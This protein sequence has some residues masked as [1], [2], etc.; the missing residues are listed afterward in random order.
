MAIINIRKE[1]KTKVNEDSLKKALRKYLKENNV[2]D[3]AEMTVALVG[4]TTMRGLGEK[5]LDET[6]GKLHNVLSFTVGDVDKNF[7]SPPGQ[8]RKL[9]EVVVCYPVA[10]DEAK[11]EGISTQEKIQS[12]AMHGILHLLGIHHAH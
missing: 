9:G 10:L 8:T 3:K 5:Y 11:K 7:V 12:L 2:G 1:P 4:E 6:D